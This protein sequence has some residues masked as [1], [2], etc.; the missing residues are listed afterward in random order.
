VV[1]AQIEALKF[2]LEN[3]NFERLRSSYPELS[4]IGEL[5]ITLMIPENHHKMEIAF[6]DIIIKCENIFI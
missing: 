4:G 3:A 6:N 1:E 5:F 2:F